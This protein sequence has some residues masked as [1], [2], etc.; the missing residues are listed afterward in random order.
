[1]FC[2]ST[3]EFTMAELFLGIEDKEAEPFKP[4]D[5]ETK[6]LR[7]LNKFNLKGKLDDAERKKKK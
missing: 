1:M 2:M 5:T 4:T 6:I 7:F 3:V